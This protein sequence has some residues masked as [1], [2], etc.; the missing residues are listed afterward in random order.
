MKRPNYAADTG[1]S[2][3]FGAVEEHGRG[4]WGGMV[5]QSGKQGVVAFGEG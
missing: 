2:S 4:L 3:E 1:C 5:M